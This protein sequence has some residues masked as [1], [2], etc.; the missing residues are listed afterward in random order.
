MKIL[1]RF[2]VPSA[3]GRIRLAL[4]A[5]LAVPLASQAQMAK[6]AKKFLGNI[7]T[8]GAV[9][10][11]F[12]NYWN[13]ITAEN[14][15]KWI[16]VEGTRNK[17]S[18]SGC[19]NVYNYAKKNGIPFKFH[20]LVWGSQ[21]P[22]WITSL[23]TTDQ[24]AEIT[25]WMDEAAKRYPDAEMI[26]VVNEAMT[27]HAPAPFKDALGGT[28]TTGFD[29]IV[30]SFKMARARWPKAKLVYNDYNVLRT[31]PAEYINICK[32]VKNAGYLDGIGCQAHGLE[33]QT[34]ATLTSSL[35]KLH[36]QIGVPV[37][38]S[39]YDVNA[40][41]DTKQK[42]VVSQQFP[43]FWESPYVAGVTIWGYVNGA[44]WQTNSGL[45]TSGGVERPALTWIKSY[46]KGKLDVTSPVDWSQST[47][48]VQEI[49]SPAVE[50]AAMVAAEVEWTDL[51]GNLVKRESRLVDR[52]AP[53]LSAPRGT[54]GMLV[55]RLTYPDGTRASI[56]R[57]GSF[58]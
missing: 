6:G 4:L 17:M 52:P 12:M 58:R 42:T 24:L 36:D 1:T 34:V 44:V 10:S 48:G 56:A 53:T 55:A 21:Y 57:L 18:W 9:R 45:M 27:G 7:T 38:I 32:A 22:T 13:Q 15:C 23:S 2:A 28:G 14:E 26:D 46:V 19:D 31:A 11:D 30:T 40:A 8:S 5:A 41:D 25:Q 33:S 3:V 43:L 47:T 39:E 35:Q 54:R 50:P 16:S 49:L 51:R 37:Y 20:T 29:W